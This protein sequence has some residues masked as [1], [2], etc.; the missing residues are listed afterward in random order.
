ME[1][2]VFD[3]T[4]ITCTLGNNLEDLSINLESLAS[5]PLNINLVVVTQ[6]NHESVE[7]LLKKSGLIYKHICDNG[8]GLSRARNIALKN[9]D[10]TAKNGLL[11]FS[12]DDNWYPNGS[13]LKTKE[14][15]EKNNFPISVFQ[16][17]DEKKE[18]Y[19]KHYPSNPYEM[20]YLD[21]LHVSSIEIVIDLNKLDINSI[22]FDEE[23]GV[24]TSI[25][26]GEENEMLIRL[27][28]KGNRIYYYPFIISYHPYKTKNIV[29][30]KKYFAEKK[31]LFAKL[32]GKV[33]GRL[34]FLAFSFKKKILDKEKR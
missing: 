11:I 5:Q 20:S 1:N 34:L 28:K 22:S 25:P 17:Y 16:Y 13:L 14:I 24:G 23:I 7:E 12:D 31:Q 3:Y 33:M 2:L 30:D 21:I 32:Y 15:V 29:F 8:R 10:K 6:G 18:V 4:I 26:S 19:P 27:K 9:V